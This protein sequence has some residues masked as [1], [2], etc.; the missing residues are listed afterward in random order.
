MAKD[1]EFG[2][3]KTVNNKERTWKKSKGTRGKNYWRF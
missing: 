3:K 1:F 2:I